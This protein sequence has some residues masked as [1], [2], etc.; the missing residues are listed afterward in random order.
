MTGRR[1][2]RSVTY[3]AATHQDAVFSPLLYSASS[4]R[5]DE[6][7]YTDQRISE[8]TRGYQKCMVKSIVLQLLRFLKHFQDY[9]ERQL[10]EIRRIPAYLEYSTAGN[11]KHCTDKEPDCT[12]QDAAFGRSFLF[13]LYFLAWITKDPSTCTK[14]LCHVAMALQLIE[15]AVRNTPQSDV[16]WVNSPAN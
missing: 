9:L 2:H 11:T 7:E 15:T 12:S 3:V 13:P 14:V 4:C 5:L 10:S 6:T 8:V 1:S 16:N